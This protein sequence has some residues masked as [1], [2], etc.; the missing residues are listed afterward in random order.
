MD[1]TEITDLLHTA[2]RSVGAEITS[3]WFYL[4]LGLILASAGIAFATSAAIRSRIDMTSFAMGWRAPAF[5]AGVLLLRRIPAWLL[6]G[7]FM[8][9]A[10][11]LPEN[12]FAG[13]FGPVGAA[14]LFYAL[15]A[16][17]LTGRD[18]LW[19]I[20]S[21]AAMASVVAHGLTGTHLSALLGTRPGRQVAP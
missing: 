13:W 10:R 21:L 19:P 11:S 20:V 7:R 1:L 15:E 12:L 8:P 3:P 17:D 6:L 4:Q 2:A 18:D 14:A 9:W 16:Q 5:A